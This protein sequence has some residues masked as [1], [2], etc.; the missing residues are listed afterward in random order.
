MQPVKDDEPQMSKPGPLLA[1]GFVGEVEK[2]SFRP[3]GPAA[4]RPR[5]ERPHW[6]FSSNAVRRLHRLQALLVHFC[7]ALK[8]RSPAWSRVSA[9]GRALG[10][11]SLPPNAITYHD[12]DDEDYIALLVLCLCFTSTQ[13]QC[14][15]VTARTLMTRR[16]KPGSSRAKTSHS[17]STGY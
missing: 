6:N 12:F 9:A 2:K 3:P 1:V 13:A 11:V 17:E 14:V 4:R 10:Q 8:Q 15:G 7:L 5:Q 16:P